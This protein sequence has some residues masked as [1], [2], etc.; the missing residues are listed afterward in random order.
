MSSARATFL[1]PQLQA[2]AMSPEAVQRALRRPVGRVAPARLDPRLLEFVPAPGSGASGDCS[3][4]VPFPEVT[5]AMS[6]EFAAAVRIVWAWEQGDIGRTRS[7]GY[8]MN[9]PRMREIREKHH[10]ILTSLRAMGGRVRL[11]ALLPASRT[12]ALHY[13]FSRVDA[14]AADA[15]WLSLPDAAGPLGDHPALRLLRTALQKARAAD[16]PRLA[17][18]TMFALIIK[19]WNA[20]RT[21]ARIDTLTFAT[22]GEDFPA[23]DGLPTPPRA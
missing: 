3:P 19:A 6:H 16:G 9:G 12:V 13:L 20:V 22:T 7:L 17:P 4:V 10:G 8:R 23:I 14:A 1:S 18:R 11:R 5:P 21:G 15:F 2:L